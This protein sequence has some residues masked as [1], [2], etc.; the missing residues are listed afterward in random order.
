ML[1]EGIPTNAEGFKGRY[2][3]PIGWSALAISLTAGVRRIGEWARTGIW[4][5]MFWSSTNC[6]FNVIPHASTMI[7]CDTRTYIVMGLLPQHP[8]NLIQ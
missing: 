1:S 6:I 2:F 5:E 8:I 3:Y 4:S 7:R